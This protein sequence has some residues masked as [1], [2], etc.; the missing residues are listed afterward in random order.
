MG[1]GGEP[2]S[3]RRARYLEFA[4]NETGGQGSLANG[5]TAERREE[6]NFPSFEPIYHEQRCAAAE[7]S[8]RRQGSRVKKSASR[9]GETA[10]LYRIAL[11]LAS[12][13][14][15]RP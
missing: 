8:L 4:T 7:S 6:G 12:H 2:G 15:V 9:G 3:L 13:R 1:K 14:S 10:S 11:E 5:P